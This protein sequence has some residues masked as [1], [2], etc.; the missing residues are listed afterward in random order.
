M[1]NP[2]PKYC[3]L[4]SISLFIATSAQAWQF[5]ID[6]L[7]NDLTFE[8]WFNPEGES[9]GVENYQLNFQ[10]DS[11]E[12][13]YVSHTNLAMAPLV[14]DLFGSPSVVNDEYLNNFNA[15]NFFGTVTETDTRYQLG[16]LTF[17]EV[18]PG[19][20]IQDG[21]DD[22]WFDITNITTKVTFSDDPLTA[23]VITSDTTL[24]GIG[25]DVGTNPVPVPGAVWLLGSG[26]LGLVAIRRRKG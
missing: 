6:N 1:K 19:T 14:P 5:E 10:F 21:L 26:L 18:N 2:L 12:L 23:I 15:A 16:T 7:E 9:I 11:E 20:S 25:L 4:L 13:S 22:I 8:L 24:N 17:A 3:F